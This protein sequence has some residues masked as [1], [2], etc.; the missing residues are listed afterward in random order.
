MKR[1]P[2]DPLVRRFIGQARIARIA[3]VSPAGNA[4]I[5][6]IWFV[7]HR[8]RIYMGTRSGNPIV[9]D[10]IRNPEVVLLFARERGRRRDR[11]L[12]IRGR[13]VFIRGGP[14]LVYVRMALRYYLPPRGLWNWIRHVRLVPVTVRYYRERGDEGGLIEIVPEMAEFLPVPG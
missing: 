1:S 3:A 12:R 11:V 14:P 8:G 9:R 4:D 2:G 5:I 7:Q 6:P 13:A 10:L